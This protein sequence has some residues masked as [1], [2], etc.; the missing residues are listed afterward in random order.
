MTQW[1]THVTLPLRIHSSQILTRPHPPRPFRALSVQRTVL[2]TT[3]APGAMAAALAAADVHVFRHEFITQFRYS[4]RATV[5]P[6]DMHILEPIADH[7][8]LYEEDKGTVFLARAVV[9]RRQKHSMAA[10]AAPGI[11]QWRSLPAHAHR[12]HY[13]RYAHGQPSRIAMAA[14]RMPR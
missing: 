14:A 5:H 6:A 8:T 2:H 4:H 7:S 10:R 12:A 3:P 11:G 9:A 1:L 13:P